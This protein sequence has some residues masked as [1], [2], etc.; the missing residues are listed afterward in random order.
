MSFEV[1]YFPFSLLYQFTQN[2]SPRAAL[3]LEF[4]HSLLM[5]ILPKTTG[6]SEDSH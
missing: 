5:H 6:T 3:E 4:L 2:R 1:L